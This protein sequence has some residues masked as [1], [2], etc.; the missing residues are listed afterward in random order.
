MAAYLSKLIGKQIPREQSIKKLGSGLASLA[1]P[2]LTWGLLPPLFMRQGY[3]GEKQ[4][5]ADF[6]VRE[7]QD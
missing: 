2:V 6:N 1:H 3:C 5:R 7:N 4:Q